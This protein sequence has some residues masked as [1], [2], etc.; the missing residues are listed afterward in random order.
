MRKYSM[1]NKKEGTA[2]CHSADG[3]THPD[4]GMALIKYEEVFVE[5]G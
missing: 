4:M 1:P 3:H 2:R 5:R